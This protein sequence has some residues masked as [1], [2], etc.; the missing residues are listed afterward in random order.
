MKAVLAIAVGILVLLQYTLWFGQ[1]GYFAQ[2]RL[3][4]QL[5]EQQERVTLLRERNEVL[6]AEVL[7]L[8]DD[9]TAVEARA[10]RDLGMIR[11]GEIFYLV[12]SEP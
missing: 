9:D 5:T 4:G 8:K 12:P 7:A 6:T 2:A 1:S 11:E 3:T 10:R